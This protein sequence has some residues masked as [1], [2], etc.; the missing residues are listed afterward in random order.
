MSMGNAEAQFDTDEALDKAI[1]RMI[2]N[3]LAD[4]DEE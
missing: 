3:L 2:E 4:T 1:E